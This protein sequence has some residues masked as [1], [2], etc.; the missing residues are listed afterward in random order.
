[1][2]PAGESVTSYF[3]PKDG[4]AAVMPPFMTFHVSSLFYFSEAFYQTSS[5]PAS[6]KHGFSGLG[7]MVE[8]EKFLF[9]D[10]E[11]AEAAKWTAG[12]TRTSPILTTK[13]TKDAYSALP[14]AYLVLGN[15]PTLPREYQEGMAAQQGSKT[16][17]FI[18]YHAPSGHSPHLSWTSGVVETALDFV[19]KTGS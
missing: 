12:L 19:K 5:L 11:S 10:L 6:Q 15:D 1:M 16:G 8:A 7:T 14:C 18:M 17:E 2:I 3:Q 9:N 4:Q 13:L